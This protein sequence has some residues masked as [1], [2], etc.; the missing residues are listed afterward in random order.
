MMNSLHRLAAAT[1][2]LCVGSCPGFAC[3]PSDDTPRETVPPQA[4]MPDTAAAPA[5]DDAWQ[6]QF[7][8][9]P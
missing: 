5:D 3:P 1:L 2:V 7:A 4:P 8:P 6:A 9:D